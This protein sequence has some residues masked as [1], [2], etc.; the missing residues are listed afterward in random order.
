MLITCLQSWIFYA[1]SELKTMPEKLKHLRS[2]IELSFSCLEYHV[3]DAMEFVADV[4]ENYPKFFE[5]GHL[6]L[7]WG[8]IT[9]QWGQDILKDLD[10]ETVSLARI[11]VAYGSEL[12][13][14]KKIFQEIES[15]H[16]RQVLCTSDAQPELNLPIF[17]KMLTRIKLSYTGS[18]TTQSRLELKM[19]SPCSRWTFGVR[20]LAR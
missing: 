4:L 1:Q 15:I 13:E 9:S 11:I 3:D 17:S 10:A 8:I 18:S 5:E 16:C 12:V 14:T 2:V 19:R 20:L 7:L 6:L